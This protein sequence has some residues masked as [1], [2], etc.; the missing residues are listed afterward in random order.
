MKAKVKYINPKRGMAALL[1]EDED[2]SIIETFGDELEI[3]DMLEWK[4][5]HPLGSEEIHNFT[6]KNNVKVYFQ[7]H[8][9]VKKQLRQQLLLE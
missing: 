8:W 2:Y 3:G 5:V 7:N 1:T 6:Q 9:I 4:A